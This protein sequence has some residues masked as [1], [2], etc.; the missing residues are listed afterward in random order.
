MFCFTSIKFYFRHKGKRKQD[1]TG[2]SNTMIGRWV[3]CGF[4]VLELEYDT[5]LAKT[6]LN[7]TTS[8]KS[9]VIQFAKKLYQSFFEYHFKSK[10]WSN[11]SLARKQCVDIIKL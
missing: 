6:N 8:Q 1:Q 2:L 11:N 3:G 9:Y 10:I 4:N 7:K 5:N